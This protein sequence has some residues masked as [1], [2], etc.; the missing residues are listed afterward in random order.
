MDIKKLLGKYQIKPNLSKD[1]FFLIDIDVIKKMADIAQ[2]T[3]EDRVLEIGTGLGFLTRELATRA[4][5]VITIE[6]DE[7]FEPILKNLPNN[8]K[9]IYGDAYRL[10]NNKNFR[11][12]V[13]PPTKTVSSIPYSQAQNMLH[14]YT[15]ATWYQRDLVWLAPISLADKVNNES[16]LGA[17]FTAKVVQT[18][19]KTAFYP[20]PN[21]SSAIIYFKRLADPKKTKNFAI[22]FRRWLYNHEGWK[23]KNALREGI[24][25]TAYDL[26][27]TI[28]TKNKA[29]QL[30]SKLGIPD[31][32]LEK[33]TNN[34][35]PKYYFEIPQKIESW[36]N[37]L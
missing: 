25:K 7:R 10:L 4:K 1:Q 26:S 30:M 16:I 32:E 18:V 11:A 13:K 22:Y 37:T 8:T 15:N 19:P 21:T 5:E 9:T 35:Q 6:I 31:N 28:V 27:G 12:E 20:Q 29:K 36:F 24:I 14:N 33:L 17:Y 2:I 34:I 23:V 3:K